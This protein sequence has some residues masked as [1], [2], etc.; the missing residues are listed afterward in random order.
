MTGE[1]T[2]DTD[3]ANY[4]DILFH[5]QVVASVDVRSHGNKVSVKTFHPDQPEDADGVFE[6]EQDGYGGDQ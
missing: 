3:G 2:V 6:Y 5:G 4:A 1:I